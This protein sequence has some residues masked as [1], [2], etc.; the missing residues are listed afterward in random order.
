MTAVYVVCFVI[1]LAAAVMALFRVERGPSM[2]DRIL[3]LDVTTAVLIG[4]VTLVAAATKRGDLVP[5]LVVLALVGFIGSVSIA[6]FAAAES[7]E[8]GRI[9]TKEELEEILAQRDAQP[10]DSS[11]D[12]EDEDSGA[13][14]VSVEA[15]DDEEHRRRDR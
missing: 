2:F 7:A 10:E 11:T 8:E 15:D 14:I 1:L 12:D 9:L 13:V 3:G 4:G 5:V 6:R